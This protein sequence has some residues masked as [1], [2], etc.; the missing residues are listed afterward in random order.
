MKNKKSI[1][2]ILL[3]TSMSFVKFNILKA[4]DVN[5]A[6]TKDSTQHYSNLLPTKL[7]D[8]SASEK[9]P[10]ANKADWKKT[11][12]PENSR[13]SLTGSCTSNSGTVYKSN[14][15]EYKDCISQLAE[16]AKERN[17]L[18]NK[19][20]ESSLDSPSKAGATIEYKFGK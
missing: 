12:P 17:N 15:P 4:A 8:T 11:K 2:A 19:K 1:L 13:V 9:S 20:I 6:K 14:E 7:G 5:A 3:L 18:E 10:E 16:E